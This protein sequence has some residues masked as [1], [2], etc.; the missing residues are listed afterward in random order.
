MLLVTVLVGLMDGMGLAM[1]LPLL[2]ITADGTGTT[3]VE[4]MGNL[5]FILRGIE[6]MGLEFTLT[7]VLLIMLIFFILKGAFQYVSTYL[8]VVYRQYFIKKL[9]TEIINSL[10][11]FRYDK[12]VT[13]DAGKIQNTMS[14]EMQRVSQAYNSYTQMM[15]QL[16]MVLVYMALAFLSNPGFAILVLVGG[17][18]TNFFFNFLF[19]KTKEISR[20][21]TKSNH[22]FQGQ[23]L[24]Q[25]NFFKYL[26]ATGLIRS[27]G[28][29]LLN[30][31]DEIEKAQK[32]LGILRGVLQGVREPIMIGVVVAVI[33]FQV[34]VLGGSLTLIILSILFFYRA[35]TA[36]M[37]LQTYQNTFL[38]MVGSLENLTE[39]TQ[40]LR[41]GEEKIGLKVINRFKDKI[42]IEGV[43]F[44]YQGNDLILEAIELTISKNE[45]LALIGESGSGK[46][47]LMNL[48]SA[49]L[50]P[51]SGNI[52]IDGINIKDIK[53]DTFQHRIGYI[54]QEPVIFDDNIFN[55]VT[56]WAGR[57]D[58]NLKRFYNALAQANI[59]EFVQEHPEQEN[60]RLGN[61]GVNLS[62]GQ[63]QRI[64]IARELYKEVDFLFMDEATSALDSETERAIQY[65]IDQL[66]GKYT[67]LIIAHRLS[68]I[69]NAD[70][71]VILN[72]GRIEEIGTYQDLIENSVSFRRMVELQDIT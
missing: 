40:E 6:W 12:F 61:N 25:V 54:T 17:G 60:M 19:T 69:K 32:K 14:G 59:L 21:L 37:Q 24:Q 34:N 7:L 72:K 45:T 68:T 36:V 23:I 71:V 56:F 47:T 10:V 35:L 1:F 65:N 13:A 50:L 55:N 67:I 51:S 29:K 49:I 64:S 33:L 11:N 9:R 38:E 26:K 20:A 66:K 63:K 70:R 3:T 62:G 39:F 28:D 46:T 8:N 43:D 52:Y 57:S 53:I 27:Y 5:A 4:Q 16:N 42:I 30:Q 18:V 15:K 22:E 2:K 44:A 41:E 48:L 58:Q 31:V